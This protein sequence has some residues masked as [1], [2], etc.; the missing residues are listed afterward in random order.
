MTKSTMPKADFCFDV[1]DNIITAEGHSYD[2]PRLH[3]LLDGPVK[4]IILDTTGKTE[5]KEIL[6]A[7]ASTDFDNQEIAKILDSDLSLEDWHI[8]EAI[9]EAFAVDYE[10]CEYPWPTN[11]DLR[12]SKSSPAGCDL[13]GFQ[14]TSHA[15][16]PYR[17]T[18]GEVKTSYDKNSPPSVVY[19]LSK[20][21]FDLRDDMGVKRD[22]VRY[23][24]IHSVGKSWLPK[25]QSSVS[26]FLQSHCSDISI[27]GLLVRDT[28]MK[29]TDL[30]GK[31]SLLSVKCPAATNISLYAIYLPP[32]SIK[33]LPSKF[34]ALLGAGSSS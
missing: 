27:L 22:L 1:S 19:S 14:S 29:K 18:F 16:H 20:Q 34:K 26:R 24:G 3:A 11:R 32:D 31:V 6:Q 21:L 13:V 5:L 4:D 8:G 28:P 17:F 9:A 10:S 30:S 33:Q 25:F 7:L 15:Q 2:D 23:L 12:N